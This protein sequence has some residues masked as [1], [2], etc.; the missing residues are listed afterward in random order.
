[1]LSLELL[2]AGYFEST[3]RASVRL[4][5][6]GGDAAVVEHMA[7]DDLQRGL[8]SLQRAQTDAAVLLRP[9]KGDRLVRRKLRTP[10]PCAHRHAPKGQQVLVAEVRQLPAV[11]SSTTSTAST[12]SGGGGA[13]GTMLC[14]LCPCV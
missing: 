12:L 11:A 13:Y 7:A 5:K 10:Q 9:C 2:L 3:D 8:A 6:P 1:M 4:S 14:C